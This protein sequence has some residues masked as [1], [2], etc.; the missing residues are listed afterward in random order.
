MWEN[1]NLLQ[2]LFANKYWYEEAMCMADFISFVLDI[3]GSPTIQG[4]PSLPN[5]PRNIGAWKLRM[6]KDGPA[7]TLSK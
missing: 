5:I 3:L 7:Q 1:N 2:T 4:M 6:A